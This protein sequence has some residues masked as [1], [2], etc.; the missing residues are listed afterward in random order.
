MSKRLFIVGGRDYDDGIARPLA[1]CTGGCH[2]GTLA[3]DC[4]LSL[5]LAPDYA[6]VIRAPI[7]TRTDQERYD[8]HRRWSKLIAVAEIAVLV[9]LLK[10]FGARSFS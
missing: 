6:R 2:Q 7:R 1:G 9:A 4:E 8:W 5:D 10:L 3:C